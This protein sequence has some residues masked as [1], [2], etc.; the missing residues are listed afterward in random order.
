[1]VMLERRQYSTSTGRPRL[2]RRT[3]A[4]FRGGGRLRRGPAGTTG[5]K[6]ID[7]VT[8]DHEA[9]AWG[10][11]RRVASES[12]CKSTGRSAA[13]SSAYGAA[14]SHDARNPTSGGGRIEDPPTW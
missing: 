1:M 8:A 4:V 6:F 7:P 3:T 10:S 11:T 2:S 5:C 9:L 14:G 13:P 12:R